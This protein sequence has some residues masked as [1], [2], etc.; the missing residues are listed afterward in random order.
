MLAP[1]TELG[2]AEEAFSR[3]EF[4]ANDTLQCM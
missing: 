4:D 3:I 2:M 1:E